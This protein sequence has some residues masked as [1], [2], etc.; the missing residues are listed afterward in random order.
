MNEVFQ[1]REPEDAQEFIKS[2]QLRVRKLGEKFYSEGRVKDLRAIKAG[3][4]YSASVQDNMAVRN[5]GIIYEE[6]AGWDGVCNCPENF[7]CAHMYA[8]MKSILAGNSLAAVRD[9]SSGVTVAG[10]SSSQVEAPKNGAVEKTKY[11]GRVADL[12]AIALGRELTRE[13]QA[14]CKKLSSIYSR[15]SVYKRITYWDL[16]E[17]GIG[18][19]GNM[20]S[21][22]LPMPSYPETELG[23]WLYIAH[24]LAESGGMVPKFLHPI[25]DLTEIREQ[26]AQQKRKQEIDQWKMNLMAMATE[27]TWSSVEEVED[28]DTR[29]SFREGKAVLEWKRPDKEFT[30]I[31]MKQ[32]RDLITWLQHGRARMTPESQMLCTLVH[33]A[34]TYEQ[35]AELVYAIERSL[36]VLAQILRAKSLE[37]STVNEQ[38]KVLLRSVEP[39]LWNVVAPTSDDGSYRFNLVRQDGSDIGAVLCS[40]PGNPSLYVTKNAVYPGPEPKR[41]LNVAKETSIPAA[42]VETR[43]GLQFLTAIGVEMPQRIRDRIR[44]VPLQIAINCE[45]RRPNAYTTAEYCYF[46]VRATSPDG[47]YTETWTGA[48]E[49][50]EAVSASKRKA[51][52]D[53]LILYDRSVAQKVAGLMEPLGLRRE[54]YSNRTMLRISKKFPEVFVPWLKSIPPNVEINLAGD[55]ASFAKD[56]VSGTVRLDVQETAIDW[57]DLSV[58]LDVSDTTLTPN[59]IKLLLNAKGGYVR[60]G[61]KGWR[62]LQFDLTAEDDERLANLGLNPRELS[63]E[64][65]R[66]HALQLADAA[67]KKFLPE[68]QAEQIQRR[69]SEIRARV[70]PPLPKGVSADLRPY[71][72]EGFHFLAY[73]HANRFGGILADDM[74]LGKT[75]QTL[76]WLLWLRE[77]PGAGSTAAS[78]VV[79]PKSVMDNWQTEAERF[80][81]GLRVKR[82]PAAELETF[83][84]RLAEAD[85]HV[86]NYSQLRILGESLIP[87]QWLAVVLDEGQYIKNP[88]SQTSQVARALR[89]DYRLVLSGTPIENRLLDLWS[90]MSFAM[91]GILSS[92]AHFAKLYDGK[93]DPL[94]RRRL[95]ARVRPFLLRRTKSQVAKDLP[96]RIEEDLFCEL[97]GEQKAL[98]RAELKRAQQNLLKI[99]TQQQLNEERFNFLTSLLRLRQICCHPALV[100]PN[101]KENGAKMEALLE[102]IEPLMQEG[103]KVLVFSQFV[104]LLSL[105]R[106]AIEER[107]WPMFY[108]TGE[109][110]NR[111]DLV[112]KFQAA[113]GSAV[114]LISLKAGGFGLNLTA[115]SYVV[116]FDP[117]WNPAVENQAID[118]THRIGQVNKVIAYR[119]LIKDSVEEKIRSLQKQKSALA[120]DVLGEEKFSQGLTLDD[121]QFLLAD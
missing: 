85:L 84:T 105:L 80:T 103:H 37:S 100:N 70:T 96:D 10:K 38:G 29:I 4:E 59:E 111:G 49:R 52:E 54:G 102:Q 109:T 60:L 92:R 93:D 23:L 72:L 113:E 51:D 25:T 55:L 75:L 2:F 41:L 14:F 88:G 104:E 61:D 53:A 47:K 77:Q 81:P 42:A 20:W 62:R 76:A 115:A 31:K 87:I 44:H 99:Q 34:I 36:A 43:A 73:L 1:M 32:L 98:Y 101:T 9:I 63:A 12:A 119:L 68:H 114:F 19:H 33:D 16:N 22:P 74:G 26:M 7:R 79:C 46:T 56:A 110:E 8:V 86:L 82:W 24:A 5:V 106:T 18:L 83:H 11:R 117:W 121:L 15:G 66:L 65:Q 48:W 108:L 69:A 78:L 3:M 58:V 94:A 57:F 21:A 97:E 50:T 67:A 64:P 91:P 116:L 71:Q 17:L 39:V 28:I 89:A 107:E 90:L 6:N 118:R 35:V 13:E 27:A 95:A 112:R 120:Q 40:I 30:Q 45:L